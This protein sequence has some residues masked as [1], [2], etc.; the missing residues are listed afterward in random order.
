MQPAPTPEREAGPHG[1]HHEP[2]HVSTET[3]RTPR[4]IP[5]AIVGATLVMG[6]PLLVPTVYDT[7][8]GHYAMYN[9]AQFDAALRDGQLPV[10]WL[11]DLFGG[12]GL[13]LFVYYHPLAFYLTSLAHASGLGIIASL[14][15]LYLLSLA[16]SGFAMF[17]W[18]RGSMTVDAAA[19]GAVAYVLAPYR[20]VEIHVKGDPPA[21]LAFV[22]MPLVL[23]AV[24]D[25]ARGKRGAVVLVALTSAG[26][27]LSHSVTALLAF[28]AMA[29]YAAL[30]LRSPARVAGGARVLAGVVLGAMLS[31]FSWLP[32]LLEKPL[33]HVDSVLGILFFDFR[34]H[35]LA[36]WQWL[37][38]LWGYHGSFAG[39]R[40]DM[41]FQ[42]GPIHALALVAG[43]VT[44]RRLRAGEERRIASW[45]LTVSAAALVMTLPV[46][47]GVWES[48]G[49]LRLVQFPWR[50]LS[51]V[52][53][54]SAALLAV[55][56]SRFSSPRLLAAIAAAPPI[57]TLIFA[58]A[59]R[60]R[61]YGLM[62]AL[63]VAAGGAAWLAFRPRGRTPGI[64]AQLAC[65]L[66]A[67][68]AF[69]WTAVP[70]HASLR[71]EPAIVALGEA[72]LSPDRVRLGVRRT[73][74]RDDYLPRTV[75]RIPARDPGQEYLPPSGAVAAPDVVPGEAHVLE[76]TRS[77]WRWRLSYEAARPGP[78]TLNL[79][80]FPGWR[81]RLVSEDG[82]DLGELHHEHDDEGRIVLQ[83]PE[84]R[85]VVEVLLE[86]TPARRLGD[87]LTV[88]GAA[89]L[90]CVAIVTGIRRSSAP[91]PRAHLAGGR[92][93]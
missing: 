27:V 44:W 5:A 89:L 83:L 8:D 4:W 34:E 74:A 66:L 71:G 65:L 18:L 81:A 32:A 35:F 9:A 45:A 79:H 41:A 64:E 70:A 23:L 82:R 92:G 56:F 20:A 54:G 47:R 61:W 36:P 2:P 21:A 48:I 87:T 58:I 63:Y 22:F 84:G 11:P 85:H 76:V 91:G 60:N 55:T 13:P 90:A 75:T 80:D 31:A 37:S 15:V 30:E 28:P 6:W 88:A 43:V 67:T 16:L 53:L 40:D 73:T 38:P 62:T 39:T 14:R 42:V 1:S 7:H 29:L 17:R 46:T 25:A 86:R 26:L 50:L 12:R 68:T 33:V 19:V 10:R 24:R 78:L 57:V 69:P 51:I 52:V 93:R 77:S 3:A 49:P 59:T 72:D